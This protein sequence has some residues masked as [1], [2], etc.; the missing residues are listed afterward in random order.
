MRSATLIRFF[1]P[2]V[3]S[4]VMCQSWMRSTILKNVSPSQRMV[5]HHFRITFEEN[6]T[7]R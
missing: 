1:F 3:Y 6:V 2:K 5:T 7:T 4:Q